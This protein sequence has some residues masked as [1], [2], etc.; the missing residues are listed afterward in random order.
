MLSHLLL[1]LWQIF[2]STD[3]LEPDQC[4]TCLFRSQETEVTEF[5]RSQTNFIQACF[6]PKDT[7][8]K[9]CVKFFTNRVCTVDVMEGVKVARDRNKNNN[10]TN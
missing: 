4:R 8:L 10:T 7:V 2:V 9:V 3:R 6:H 1:P 5:R